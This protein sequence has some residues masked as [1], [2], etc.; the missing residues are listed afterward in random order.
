MF[1]LLFIIMLLAT[2]QNEGRTGEARHVTN[3][4]F[5]FPCMKVELDQGKPTMMDMSLQSPYATF[6]Q[7]LFELIQI[8]PHPARAVQDGTLN[9]L[10][11]RNI[12]LPRPFLNEFEHRPYPKGLQNLIGAGPKRCF[13]S[14]AEMWA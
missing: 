13:P 6:P 1:C 11:V 3:W 12:L 8:Q 4:L 10:D 9:F 14:K 7:R 5:S 2:G